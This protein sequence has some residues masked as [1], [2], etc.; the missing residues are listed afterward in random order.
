M[1][2]LNDS[3]KI[4]ETLLG[5]N[6]S[7]SKLVMMLWQN[8]RKF[9]WNNFNETGKNYKEI[10]EKL[11]KNKGNILHKL[12]RRHF[13]GNFVKFSKQF[14]K[15]L[16]KDSNNFREKLQTNPEKILEIFGALLKIYTETLQNWIC[17]GAHHSKSNKPNFL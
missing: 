1:K 7:N 15:E 17:T 11:L 12:L 6:W 4:M 14:S 13:D 10:L 9:F 3:E 5:K 8:F 2:I 16:T